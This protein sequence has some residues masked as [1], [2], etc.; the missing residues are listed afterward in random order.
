MKGL[1]ALLVPSAGI[2]G[3]KVQVQY[4]CGATAGVE[5]TVSL[6]G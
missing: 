6:V 4:L 3:V 5:V 2:A 1:Q